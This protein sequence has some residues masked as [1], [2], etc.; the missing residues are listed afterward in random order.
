MAQLTPQAVELIERRAFGKRKPAGWIRIRRT[1]TASNRPARSGRGLSSRTARGRPVSRLSPVCKSATWD[2]YRHAFG[3]EFRI[4]DMHPTD[5]LLALAS[6]RPPRP[7]RVNR[8]FQGGCHPLRPLAAGVYVARGAR[9]SQRQHGLSPGIAPAARG[10]ERCPQRSLA[11][12][13]K[14]DGQLI[15]VA[16]AAAYLNA[17]AH[18]QEGR[19][20]PPAAEAQGRASRRTEHDRGP[21]RGY[22][23]N[24]PAQRRSRP[25]HDRGLAIDVRAADRGQ[26]SAGSRV[27]RAGQR[28]AGRRRGAGRPDASGDPFRR[29]MRGC[30]PSAA[31]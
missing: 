4:T 23:R 7:R 27:A 8:Y 30:T 1:R 21:G 24:R 25:A 31:R 29:V 14:A 18:H 22:G 9:V 12:F 13:L 17:E 11:E 6:R 3:Q 26:A 28:P 10:L 15:E 20:Q 5:E 16:Q 2:I 19:V